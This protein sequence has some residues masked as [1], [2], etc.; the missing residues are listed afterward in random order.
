[1]DMLQEEME[2]KIKKVELNLRELEQYDRV[3]KLK[4]EN[5]LEL[6]EMI[7]SLQKEVDELKRKIA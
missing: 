3:N 4:L 2:E 7:K 6:L 1:M 5:M